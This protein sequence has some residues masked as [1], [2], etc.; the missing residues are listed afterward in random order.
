MRLTND[1][2]KLVQYLAL[3]GIGSINPVGYEWARRIGDAEWRYFPDSRGRKGPPGS[4]F[5][6]NTY[7][8][9]ILSPRSAIE[10]EELDWTGPGEEHAFSTF[11][12]ELGDGSSPVE[13]VSDSFTPLVK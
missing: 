13:I 9:L 1:G 4:E 3:R 8:W 10:Y 11:V 7:G 6:G 12:K 2:P 5:S